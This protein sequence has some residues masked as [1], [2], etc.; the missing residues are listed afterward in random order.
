MLQYRAS[1][2]QIAAATHGR[3]LFTTMKYAPFNKMTFATSSQTVN[4]T[5]CTFGTSCRKYKDIT[6]PVAIT[7]PVSTSDA[8][9]TLTANG[10]STAVAGRDYAIQTPTFTFLQNGAIKQNPVVRIYD[11]DV[12]DG[13][14]TLI[15]D[16]AETSP[17]ITA[18][19]IGTHT[20][21]IKNDDVAPDIA[22]AN[23][24]TVTV[25]SENFD[26][27][28]TGTIG[29]WT[30]ETSV[31]PVNA[32]TV[33]ASGGTGF[34]NKSM[35]ISSGAGAFSYNKSAFCTDVLF[36]PPIN[37]TNY[38]NLSLSVKYKSNGE[39][40]AG[41][42]YDFGKIGY[43]LD[44]GAS[45]TFLTPELQGVTTA[46]S[47][48]LAL[49]AAANNA[50]NLKLVFHWENDD[51][52]GGNPPFGIDDLVLSGTATTYSPATIQT[53]VNSTVGENYLGANETVSFYD[54]A[55]GAIMATIQNNSA[56]DFGCTKV[57]IDRAGTSATTFWNNTPANKAIDKTI[58]ITP[59]T[60]N[61]SAN[62][63]ITLFY[64]KPE[65]DGWIATTGN[66][67]S[68][69]KLIK[70][71]NHAISEVTIAT[72]YISDVVGGE[73]T[74]QAS[75]NGTHYKFTCNFDGFS[76]F[77]GGK[78]GAALPVTLVSFSGRYTNNAVVLNWETKGE[79]NNSGFEIQTAASTN[80]N[81]Q[82]AW[83]TI[84]FVTGNGTTTSPHSYSF[85]DDA[86]RYG[87]Q[88]YRLKQ[89]DYDKKFEYSNSIS[90]KMPESDYIA[91]SPNPV[92]A[93]TTISF[94]QPIST[95]I[96]LELVDAAGK[97][98]QTET[99][100]PYGQLH[101]N[102]Q[103]VENLSAGLYILKV[104]TNNTVHSLRLIKE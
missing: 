1:D 64:T 88:Y 17:D 70:I 68:D 7:K 9:I 50:S 99:I 41:I 79:L 24:T 83:Q 91:I 48:V 49:P 82:N 14:R 58:K 90:I 95:E 47:I 21:T 39:L 43:S 54:D 65:I 104:N 76:G 16:I 6:L 26:N 11:N 32:W 5:D 80:I 37:A 42:Y 85:T 61:P 18:T 34:T 52:A 71:A 40:Y 25:F 103:L 72:P 28:T 20:I 2:G 59:T 94:A 10:A 62:Y 23:N 77:G 45:Y 4:E 73:S 87:I 74:T 53:A 46:T 30:Q 81:E 78:I 29:T 101:V 93:A 12:V 84:G 97:L 13:A 31:A 98:V 8:I 57:E 35:Y 15:L 100:S 22:I 96:V 92:H 56:H 102:F 63:T 69:F 89:L 3:G 60:N 27:I 36:S 38:T 86:K 66:T 51:S 19:I 67:I 33:G 55:T 75:F 44:G